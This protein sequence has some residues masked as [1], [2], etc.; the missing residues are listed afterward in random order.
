MTKVPH[1]RMELLAAAAHA[2]LDDERHDDGRDAFGGEVDERGGGG[3]LDDGGRDEADGEGLGRTRPDDE[4]GEA[5][6]GDD[7][8]A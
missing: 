4:D 1:E 2:R 3:H 7:E 6:G 5:E 8:L